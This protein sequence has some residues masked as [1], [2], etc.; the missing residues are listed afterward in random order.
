[1]VSSESIF[2]FCLRH[3]SKGNCDE[4]KSMF[5]FFAVN[6]LLLL[7]LLLF[8]GCHPV[9]RYHHHRRRRHRVHFQNTL[10]V[11]VLSSPCHPITSILLLHKTTIPCSTYKSPRDTC[12]GSSFLSLS[13]RLCFGDLVQIKNKASHFQKK[14]K[15]TS[16]RWF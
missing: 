13:L 15:K 3:R 9:S 4:G 6:W 16:W 5:S 14:K 8:L 10:I 11:P 12:I 2:R 7:L 1:M